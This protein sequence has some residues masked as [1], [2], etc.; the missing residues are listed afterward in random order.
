MKIRTGFVSNSSSSSFVVACPIN[1]DWTK[2]LTD[3]EIQ[4]FK[5]SFYSRKKNAFGEQVTVYE[6]YEDDEND[7]YNSSTFNKLYEDSDEY[8]EKASELW[9]KFPSLFKDDECFVHWMEC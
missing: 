4:I 7:I 2:G 5:E 3:E 8:Y 9:C 1:Y 6:G